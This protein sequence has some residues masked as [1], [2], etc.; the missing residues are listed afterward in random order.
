MLFTSARSCDD[1]INQ[2]LLQLHFQSI[3]V[4]FYAT[5]IIPQVTNLAFIID[6]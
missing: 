1:N 5:P 6:I 3:F 2:K 4:Y